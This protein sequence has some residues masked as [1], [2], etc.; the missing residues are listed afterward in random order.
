MEGFEGVGGVRLGVRPLVMGVGGED[1]WAV[2]L[3][4]REEV[5]SVLDFSK[6]GRRISEG[7][8]VM[9]FLGRCVRRW[10]GRR[11]EGERVRCG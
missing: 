6:V 8:P 2:K 7:V 4:R 3:E 11:V 1:W 5:S 10:D 9:M